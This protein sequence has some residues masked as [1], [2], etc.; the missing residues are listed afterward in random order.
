ML[1]G[2]RHCC[3]PP[4][5]HRFP[6]RCRTSN[7]GMARKQTW[8]SICAPG[9]RIVLR[10]SSTL[11]LSR[12][13]PVPDRPVFI[14]RRRWRRTFSEASPA[15][16]RH[17]RWL[18]PAAWRGQPRRDRSQRPALGQTFRKSRC[19][20][21][22]RPVQIDIKTLI[23]QD[24][25]SLCKKDG[26]T[27]SE[28]RKAESGCEIAHRHAKLW[29]TVDKFAGNFRAGAQGID[30]RCLSSGDPGPAKVTRRSHYRDSF[31]PGEPV[32]GKG[33]SRLAKEL[34]PA[35]HRLRDVGQR[36]FERCRPASRECNIGTARS[37]QKRTTSWR[38]RPF[39]IRSRSALTPVRDQSVNAADHVGTGNAGSR[40]IGSNK[41]LPETHVKSPW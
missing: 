38:C 5:H 35:C 27:R 39:L 40:D 32:M 29:M 3:R 30:L 34:D 20:A 16:R 8:R 18:R 24:F 26:L 19:R 4:L 13:M 11:T 17:A 33:I 1:N 28:S 10:Q 37:A 36:L 14:A 41:L 22:L 7:D 21:L 2:G 23:S 31:C 25:R 15:P 6:I 9:F 12:R